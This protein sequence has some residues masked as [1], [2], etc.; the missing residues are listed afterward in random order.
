M[1]HIGDKVFYPM[2]GAGVIEAIEEREILGEMQQYCVFTIPSSNMDV[3]I[4]MKNM[5]KTGIRQVVDR[6]TVKEILF[7]FHNAEPD[8]QLP[9]KERF[10]QNSDKMK[11][12]EMQDGAEVVRDL[13]FRMK[14]K[15]LNASEK[16]MF[17]NAKKILISELSLIKDISEM[18][19]ADMLEITH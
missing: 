3:M 8:C 1:F 18:Q 14:E 10:K 19:A 12:G 17:T 2:H 11:T 5:R 9:W 16:Q 4:P 15:P 6:N 13:L 7:D